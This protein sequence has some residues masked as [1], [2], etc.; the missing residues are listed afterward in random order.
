MSDPFWLSD[1]KTAHLQLYFSKPHGMPR[2]DDRR[3]LSGFIVINCNGV[4]WRNAPKVYG[5]HG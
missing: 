5:P 4:R 3:V 2:V 1:T